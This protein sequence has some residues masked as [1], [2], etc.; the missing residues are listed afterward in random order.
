MDIQAV[1]HLTEDGNKGE[2]MIDFIIKAIPILTFVLF[3]LI[4]GYI[5]LNHKGK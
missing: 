2:T 1:K 4:I 5:F 3:F